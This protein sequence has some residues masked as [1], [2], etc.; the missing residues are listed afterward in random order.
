MKAN[1]LRIGNL[2]YL[3]PVNELVKIN[4]L[5]QETEGKITFLELGMYEPIQ[6]TEKYLTSLGFE[7]SEKMNDGFL[8]YEKLWEKLDIDDGGD[9]YF[10]ILKHGSQDYWI[11]DN[12]EYPFY[13]RLQYIH[14]LQNL[15][16]A[17]TGEELIYKP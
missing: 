17:L 3:I 10:E 9:R 4:K 2:V 1:E 7:C 6:I 11:C 13:V 15:H 8:R 12:L 5:Q 16:F 14:Q